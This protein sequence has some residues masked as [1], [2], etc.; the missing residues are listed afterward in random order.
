MGGD[1]AIVIRY[2]IQS[3]CEATVDYFLIKESEKCQQLVIKVFG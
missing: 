1:A 3:S 2:S